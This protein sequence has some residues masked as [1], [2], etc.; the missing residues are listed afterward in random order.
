VF[1]RKQTLS[2]HGGKDLWLTGKRLQGGQRETKANPKEFNFLRPGFSRLDANGVAESR[3][4]RVFPAWRYSLNSSRQA[5]GGIVGMAIAVASI[6]THFD[7]IMDS[8]VRC[9]P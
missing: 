7:P 9:R 2:G 1:I 8:V 5:T 6:S 3:I 4:A